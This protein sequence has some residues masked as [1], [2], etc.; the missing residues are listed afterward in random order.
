[1]L[2]SSLVAQLVK[3]PLAMQETL[4]WFQGWG[5]NGPLQEGIKDKLPT[6][7]FLGFPSGSDGKESA[8]NA[9]DLGLIPG[10][11]R[12]SGEAHGKPLQSSCLEHTTVYGV[13][14]SQT[15]LSDSAQ[16]STG[17]CIFMDFNFPYCI[18]REFTQS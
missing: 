18:F 4:V 7:V 3:N 14:E 1:M 5:L 15:R 12:S 2:C 6:P 17:L 16:H 9:G 8:S 10:L 13:T 11:G